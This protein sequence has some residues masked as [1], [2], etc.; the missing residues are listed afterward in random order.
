M[1][2]RCFAGCMPCTLP[3]LLSR[4]R[5]PKVDALSLP[6]EA[7]AVTAE[8]AV[9]P[10][11]LAGGSMC[12]SIGQSD[13][14]KAGIR[15][16]EEIDV[17]LGSVNGRVPRLRGL[18]SRMSEASQSD[19]ASLSKAPS[20]RCRRSGRKSGS[21]VGTVSRQISEASMMSSTIKGQ[22]S[23]R[24]R[25]SLEAAQLRGL[26]H[27]PSEASM[28]HAWLEGESLPAGSSCGDFP[29][30]DDLGTP[31]ESSIIAESSGVRRRSSRRATG[32]SAT[33]GRSSAAGGDVA[34]LDDLDTPKGSSIIAES[35][36]MRRR[37]SRRTTGG[38]ATPGRNSVAGGGAS[39][40]STESRRTAKKTPRGGGASVRSGRSMA[41]SRVLD[42]SRLQVQPVVAE[43]MAKE[44]SAWA[45]SLDGLGPIQRAVGERALEASQVAAQWALEASVVLGKQALAK[46]QD[47]SVFLG[48]QAH[49]MAVHSWPLL[50]DA[51]DGAR[52][53]A[54][55]ASTVAAGTA[56]EAFSS[57]LQKF[58]HCMAPLP[59]ETSSSWGSSEE[60]DEEEEEEDEE[61]TGDERD[62]E[63]GDLPSLSP[64]PAAFSAPPQLIASPVLVA[65]G[66]GQAYASCSNSTTGQHPQQKWVVSSPPQAH[67][68]TTFDH[69]SQSQ[70]QQPML[71]RAA[72]SFGHHEV[73][74]PILS[75]AS[76]WSHDEL[77]FP[78]AA[79]TSRAAIAS[80]PP[81]AAVAFASAL[82]PQRVVAAS[83]WAATGSLAR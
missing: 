47:A 36:G 3:T 60:W 30:H 61:E 22:R 20:E 46:G 80:R 62:D 55:E 40:R 12:Q 1:V 65:R 83:S 69:G 2:R 41:S 53:L 43:Q 21:S 49:Q 25:R 48:G 37:S 6:L 42:S 51:A 63:V 77:A 68:A 56:Q 82:A 26:S 27:N 57:S 28:L 8:E 33:P 74:Q 70:M 81:A 31:K 19:L 17:D 9:P 75:R 52:H 39:A 58:S 16:F 66:H 18:S 76:T 45:S 79:G 73:C 13:L 5:A 32:G 23:S 71:G 72:S 14:E 64:S 50:V 59:E 35:S 44:A 67:R 11:L 7:K 34:G 10:T 38:S 78:G 4:R 24:S 29:F 15:V 54:V